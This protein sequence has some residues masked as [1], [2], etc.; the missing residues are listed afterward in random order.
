MMSKPIYQRFDYQNPEYKVIPDL[1]KNELTLQLRDPKTR[2]TRASL[3]FRDPAG[4]MQ[5]I[6]L[7]YEGIDATW[8]EFTAWMAEEQRKARDDSQPPGA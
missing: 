8:P 5:M 3:T 4:I 7:L 1:V 2:S 6:T